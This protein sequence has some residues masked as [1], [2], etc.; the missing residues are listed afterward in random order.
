MG[1]HEPS[2][3]DASPLLLLT[4]GDRARVRKQSSHSK[5]EWYQVHLRNGETI[6]GND[7]PVPNKVR[8]VFKKGGKKTDTIEREK[9][10]LIS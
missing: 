8:F 4:S 7:G 2:T 3:G 5:P 10:S 1:S 9:Q 6:L